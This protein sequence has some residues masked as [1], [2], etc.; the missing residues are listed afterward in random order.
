M[1]VYECENCGKMFSHKGMLNRHLDKK[2]PCVFKN[3]NE[4]LDAL[5]KKLEEIQN[6]NNKKTNT[7]DE[8][9][10]KID[11]LITENE[12]I[13]NEIIKLKKINGISNSNNSI[14]NTNNAHN[15]ANNAHN[16]IN[17]AN[18]NYYVVINA[19][20]KEDPKNLFDEK[21]IKKIFDKGYNAIPEY[22]RT[23]H[24]DENVP[25]NHNI[26]MPNWRDKSKVLT[27]DG[28]NWNLEDS[29]SKIDDLKSKGIDFIEK[30]YDDLDPNNKK[31]AVALKKID[32]FLESYKNDDK[33]K[34][35]I[36]HNEILLILYNNR[37]VT[38]KT[39][40]DKKA[41]NTN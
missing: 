2:N 10:K 8:L 22:V 13:K 36:L 28:H 4:K 14:N 23:L 17:N 26:Y 20:G 18:N 35:A 5:I 7:N 12:I 32:R 25:E 33:E 1:S 15:N 39:R 16:N 3:S 38:E 31:D 11:E 19:F 34:M 24:F 27:Y 29:V 41:L 40:K 37:K 21:Q 6:E 30:Y 9:L